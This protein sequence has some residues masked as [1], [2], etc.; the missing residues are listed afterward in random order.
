MSSRHWVRTWGLSRVVFTVIYDA[1]VL[2]PSM[3]RDLLIRVAQAGLVRARWTEAI[4]D[5]TFRNLKQNRPD[6]D[7]A[8]LDRTRELMCAAVPDCIVD[9]YQPLEQ[10]FMGLPD[11]GDA[12][13]MAAALKVQAQVIVTNNLKHFPAEVLGRWGVEAKHPMISSWTSS[14]WTR[15][16]ST[17][18]CATCPRPTGIHRWA[19]TMS[20]IVSSP[21]ECLKSRQPFAGKTHTILVQRPDQRFLVEATRS[22]TTAVVSGPRQGK[23][24]Q[25]HGRCVTLSAIGL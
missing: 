15:W 14:T 19:L 23:G 5:E 24:H 12:H 7:P 22:W 20:W 16:N 6:L 21:R 10:V 2:Y 9:D 11:P 1:N 13:V 18:P 4:L 17:L 25:P 3:L 8:K